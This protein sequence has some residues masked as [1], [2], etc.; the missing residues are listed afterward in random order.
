MRGRPRKV[1]VELIEK[2][3]INNKRLV[4]YLANKYREKGLKNG[5]L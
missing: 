4:E 2:E 1:I 5:D 3:N